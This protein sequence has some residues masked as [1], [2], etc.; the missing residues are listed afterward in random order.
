MQMK[1]CYGDVYL[2]CIIEL[3]SDKVALNAEKL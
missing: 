3:M 1:L 2:I